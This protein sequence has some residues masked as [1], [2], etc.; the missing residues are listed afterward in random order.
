MTYFLPSYLR[1]ANFAP[2]H[3]PKNAMLISLIFSIEINLIRKK[4]IMFQ[5][6]IS[7]LNQIFI[8]VVMTDVLIQIKSPGRVN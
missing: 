3:V 2:C 7:L 1:A 8:S 6:F 5:D 4:N